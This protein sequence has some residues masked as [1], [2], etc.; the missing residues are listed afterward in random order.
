MYIHAF[1]CFFL[2]YNCVQ[3][4]TGFMNLEDDIL[5]VENLEGRQGRKG[6]VRVFGSLPIKSSSMV[7]LPSSSSGMDIN[8]HEMEVG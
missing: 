2:C 5:R 7:T 8:I 4:L 6:L 3:G 1:E